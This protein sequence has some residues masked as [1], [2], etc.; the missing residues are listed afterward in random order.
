M[1]FIP[2]RGKIG[3]HADMQTIDYLEFY[4]DILLLILVLQ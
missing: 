4:T 3:Q 1:R 2:I